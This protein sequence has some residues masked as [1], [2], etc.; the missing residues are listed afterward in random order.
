LKAPF[1]SLLQR[2]NLT[3]ATAT[4]AAQKVDSIINKAGKFQQQRLLFNIA[5]CPREAKSGYRGRFCR[6]R[7]AVTQARP[8]VRVWRGGAPWRGQG[9]RI[10][11]CLKPERGMIGLGDSGR[12][13]P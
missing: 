9:S 3:S 6:R 8:L 2:L 1:Q 7:L 13:N 5:E 12:G 4:S 11:A 10:G